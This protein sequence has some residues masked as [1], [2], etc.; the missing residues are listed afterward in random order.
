MNEYYYILGLSENASKEAIKEAYRKLS[1]KFHPDL[2]EGDK[3]FEERFKEIQEA[4]EI[5][6]NDEKRKQYDNNKFN[7]NDD[8]NLK[9]CPFCYELIKIEAIKCKHCGEI[10]NNNKTTILPELIAII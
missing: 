8:K 2:N 9:Q 7:K 4:Y 6:M 5:L 3:Y 10:L 1:K